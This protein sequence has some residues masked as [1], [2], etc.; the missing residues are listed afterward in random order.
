MPFEVVT[1][2]F[3]LWVP[4]CPATAARVVLCRR[5][6]NVG[7]EGRTGI[8]RDHRT[9]RHTVAAWWQAIY[10]VSGVSNTQIARHNAAH[11]AIRLNRLI[12]SRR[13]PKVDLGQI[14]ADPDD[15][16]QMFEIF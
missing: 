1:Y 13:Q 14:Q 2:Q 10:Q 16:S 7:S 3:N 5:R 11:S 4:A 12:L 6:A 15:L 8:A 9:C